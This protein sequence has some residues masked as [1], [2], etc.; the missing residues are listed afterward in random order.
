MTLY[1]GF[2]YDSQVRV[3]IT[4][5]GRPYALPGYA[6]YDWGESNTYSMNLAFDILK[7]HLDESTALYYH[8]EFCV[9]VISRLPPVSWAITD[10]YIDVWFQARQAGCKPIERVFAWLNQE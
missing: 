10:D 1:S 3:T 2:R 4:Q 7:H 6:Y 8:G 5:N 9:D